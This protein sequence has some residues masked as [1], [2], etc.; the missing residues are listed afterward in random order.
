VGKGKLKE[1]VHQWLRDKAYVKQFS[2]TYDPLYG[3]GA[4][5]IIFQ[6]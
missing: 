6:Y 5:T 4:T 1:E 2:N 3:A